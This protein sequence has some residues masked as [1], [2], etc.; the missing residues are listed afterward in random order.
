MKIVIVITGMSFGGA[1]RVTTHLANYFFLQGNEVSIIT[2]MNTDI[3]YP[4]EEGISCIQLD[5]SLKRNSLVRYC[6]LVR[7]IRKEIQGIKPDIILGMMSYSGS[8]AAVASLG[9]K[10]P[11]VISERNDPSTSTAF[12]EWEKKIIRFVYRHFV[13]KAIFQTQGAMSYYYRKDDR[14]GVVIGNPLYLEDIPAP[15]SSTNETKQIISVGRLSIQ[16]NYS[17]LIEAFS[18]V[19]SKYPDYTLTIYGEGDLRVVLER[20]IQQNN[21]SHCVFLPGIEKDIFKKLQTAEM[22]VLSSDFEGMPNALLEAMAMGLPVISTDYSGGN[23]TLI[24]HMKDGIVVPRMNSSLLAEAMLFLIEHPE[25]RKKL[26][27]EAVK[28]RDELDSRIISKKW[29]ATIEQVCNDY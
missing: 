15:N 9:M 7:R 29:L 21:L 18:K 13:T 8:L 6:S 11:F 23:G 26:G 10:I 5:E 20:Q 16:K 17:L 28:V 12:S 25:I 24:S 4:L 2:L 14:R 3:A 1:E 22:F 19:I 27:K